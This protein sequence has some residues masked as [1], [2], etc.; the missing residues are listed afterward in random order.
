MPTKRDQPRGRK[1]WRCPKCGGLILSR[2]CLACYLAAAEAARRAVRELEAQG[3]F[4]A[5]QAAANGRQAAETS[6]I[7]IPPGQRNTGRFWAVSGQ[8]QNR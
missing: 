3:A 6:P 7:I 1:P 2:R 5:H 4:P 8:C